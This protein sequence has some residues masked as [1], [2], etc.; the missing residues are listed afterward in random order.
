MIRIKCQCGRKLKLDPGHLG[1]SVPCP[2]CGDAISLHCA[3]ATSPPE[4]MTF[5]LV[6]DQG[7]E[8]VG[9]QMFL[10]GSKPM[11]VGKS[12][13]HHIR[14][15]GA[16][17]SRRHCRLVPLGDAW[18]VQDLGS[19]NGTFVNQQRA[20][21]CNLADG[22]VLRI[23]EYR[24]VCREADAIRMAEVPDDSP[25]N[26]APAL[27]EGP[28]LPMPPP[29]PGAAPKPTGPP[30][31]CPSC[32]EQLPHG[33]VICV[34]CGINIKTGRSILTADESGLDQAQAATESIVSAISWLICFGIYPVRSEAFGKCKPHAIRALAA[35]TIAVT[36]AVWG[37][38][39]AVPNGVAASKNLMLW[40]GEAEPSAE[41]LQ[42]MCL[43]GGV[44]EPD[45]LQAAISSKLGPKIRG[46]EKAATDEVDFDKVFVEAHNALPEEAQCV[47]H[48]HAYQ[49]LTH[50]LLHG[51]L[52]HLLGNLLFLMVLGTRVNSLIGNPATLVIYP[53]L[54]I[55]GAV[56]QLVTSVDQMPYPMLGASGAIMG[57][58][59]M[60][61]VLFP[62]NK[63]HMVYWWRFG[64]IGW[65][66]LHMRQFAVRGL[67]V[68]A[69]YI[70]FDVF[71]TAL[72]VEDGTA[73]WA[74]LGGFIAGAG[75]AIV[76]VLARLVNARG[77]DIFSAL[78][79]R[80][81]W[82]LVGKPSVDRKALF[83]G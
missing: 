48:F 60:Y 62:M 51:G 63:M 23:G 30:P 57:L 35:V 17:V 72:G 33:A 20:T 4:R 65:F 59:G 29:P 69:F 27:S 74:H 79:G 26:L 5:A 40:G 77:G 53:L 55:A 45:K 68:V 37:Y 1:A 46:P 78:L 32:Q 73:H 11:T 64:L 28:S 19:S 83:G 56:G 39:L 12:A 44:G 14:L 75:I 10:G 2:A 81:A 16:A 25:P 54:A 76:L 31:Q 18:V 7:P 67:W 8:R 70:A 47:G 6:V 42:A 3:D 41:H 66:E 80:H 34:R 82:A 38:H 36:V 24:L 15:P 43:Y 50:A 13:D 21:E 58:A 49:L 61:F 22:D 52:L 71:Y 9:E